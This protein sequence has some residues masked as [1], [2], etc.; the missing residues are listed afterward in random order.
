M[1]WYYA[2]S[3]QQTGPI[4]DAEFAKMV[5]EGH[6]SPDALVWGTSMN[7]WTPCSKVFDADGQLI[8]KSG[9]G[10]CTC[11]ECGRKFPN[12]QPGPPSPNFVCASCKPRY[13]RDLADKEKQKT[14]AGGVRY[15]YAGIGLRLCAKIGD[16]I[17]L[18]GIGVA[19]A[20][21]LKFFGVISAETSKS[22]L[23]MLD[24]LLFIGFRIAYNTWFIGSSNAT[25]GKSM[26]SLSVIR[27]DGSDVSYGIAFVRS[28]A[29][30][31]CIATFGI[32]YIIAAF[33]DQKRGLHDHICGTRVI[34]R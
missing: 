12:E 10:T 19:L 20:M 30:F 5:K 6:V 28:L 26:M 4:D 16:N 2:R 8:V 9:N 32:G 15:R 31:L 3:G 14:M 17:I 23:Q 1:A 33:D 29:E 13:L 21:S 34:Q 25:P 18:W 27:S 11:S 7:E 24:A 22:T